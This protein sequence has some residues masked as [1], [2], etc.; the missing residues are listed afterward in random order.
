ME[1]YLHWTSLLESVMKSQDLLEYVD[2]TTSAP[3]IVIKDEKPELNPEFR[4]W[5][6]AERLA[7]SWIKATV[8]NSVMGQ[9]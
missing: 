9:L 1:N 7:L 5:H 8:G 3:K 2:G 4:K 6:R